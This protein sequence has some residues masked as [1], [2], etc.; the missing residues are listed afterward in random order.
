MSAMAA[1]QKISDE[2]RTLKEDWTE[3]F[4]FIERSGKLSCLICNETITV[5]KE[6]NVW[7]H[8]E[9]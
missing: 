4:F 5:K 7:R 6:Y 2:H 3:R 8:Y 1:K 9:N